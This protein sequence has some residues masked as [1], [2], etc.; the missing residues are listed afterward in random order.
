MLRLPGYSPQHG[1]IFL[2]IIIA[3]G[4][5]AALIGAIASLVVA[6]YDL[7]GYSRTRITARHLAT[8]KMEIIRNLP[9]S[10]VAVLG[11]VPAGS[12]PQL[13]TIERNGL[14]Y[15][16]RTNVVYIDDPFDGLAP[17]DM[18]PIDYKRA[19]VD[20]SWTGT[21]ASDATITMITDIAPK[22]IESVGE[23]GTL[24]ILVFDALAQ[25]VPQAEVRIQNAEVNPAIDLTVLSDSNGRVMLPGSPVCF[26]CYQITVTKEG[27]SLDRTYTTAEVA[28]PAKP[29][30]TVNDQSIT[31]ISFAIDRVAT[32]T[33]YSTR[34]REDGYAFLSNQFFQLT[35]T[36]QIG[37]DT[38]E[39]PVFKYDVLNKTDNG[40]SVTLSNM[41]WDIY[42]LTI[43]SPDWDF[44]GSN[45]FSP[46]ALLP[47]GSQIW[48]FVTVP[49]QD[50]TLLFKV[51]EASG[52]AI[53][54]ATLHLLGPGNYDEALFSGPAAAPDFG[55]AFFSPLTAGT[56]SGEA[57]KSGYLTT[58]FEATASGNV[59]NTLILNPL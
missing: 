29:P 56:Y 7:V 10:E 1:S 50:Y 51:T 33:V 11:G 42:T 34:G 9:Y 32:L 16:I 25:V 59:T 3:I 48:Q 52:S 40:G 15:T 45:P 31:E 2:E 21:F 18:L 46:L 23:G 17:A 4:I 38:L 53:P 41:E 44:A 8:E 49:H 20:V 54:D 35:G 47:G 37:T 30:A 39:D 14:P 55:Q 28:H 12:L 27:F 26:E 5:L 6:S 58:S 24:S 19:R 22:G 13:E 57:T 43:P 36:K